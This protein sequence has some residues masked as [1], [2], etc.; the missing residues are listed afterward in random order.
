MLLCTLVPAVDYICQA[1]VLGA[2]KISWLT[3]TLKLRFILLDSFVMGI[4]AADLVMQILTQSLLI[5]S[6]SDSTKSRYLAFGAASN[7]LGMVVCALPLWTSTKPPSSLPAGGAVDIF[8]FKLSSAFCLAAALWV[9]ITISPRSPVPGAA[10]A[11]ASAER[12]SPSQGSSSE[13]TTVSRPAFGSF[14]GLEERRWAARIRASFR[15]LVLLSPLHDGPTRDWSLA[16]VLIAASLCSQIGLATAN[17]VIFAQAQFAFHSDEI[18]ALLGVQGALTITFLLALFPFVKQTLQRRS[19]A[20]YAHVQTSTTI[21]HGSEHGP[22]Q[23]SDISSR[24][25]LRL[26]KVSLLFDVAGWALLT[27][28]GARHNLPT[29]IAG[30]FVYELSTASGPTL[31]SLGTVLL[32]RRSGQFTEPVMLS[33]LGV[34]NNII[35]VF[36]PILNNMIYTL[37]L[38]HQ[39]SEIVFAFTALVSALALLL[40]HCVHIHAPLARD[41]ID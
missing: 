3:P 10:V 26:A 31:I 33:L 29:F 8:P 34:L 9:A 6:A 35:A 21:P 23:L 24:V 11:T 7:Y 25:D 22:A 16:N 40:V 17:T 12:T 19:K 4:L 36:G 30:L 28:G 13:A 5:R 32:A 2:A 41:C 37:G 38:S 20:R 1:C 14:S 39:H 27:I 18:S 15:P